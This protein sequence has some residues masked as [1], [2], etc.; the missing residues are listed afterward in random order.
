MIFQLPTAK[1]ES[2]FVHLCSANINE[3]QECGCSVYV[4][5]SITRFICFHINQVVASQNISTTVQIK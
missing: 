2:I 1:E 3:N 4:Q 5:L